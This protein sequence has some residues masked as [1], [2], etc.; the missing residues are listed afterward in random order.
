MSR[1]LG[2]VA[3]SA[4]AACSGGGALVVVE[5]SA[6]APLPRVARLHVQAATVT[7]ATPAF[8]TEAPD[9]GVSFPTDFA[10]DVPAGIDG[11]LFIQVQAED[12]AARI[13]A[14]GNGSAPIKPGA[15]STAMI[16]LT[17]M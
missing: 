8:D 1:L 13:V 12:D 5:V 14:S 4:L 3:V 2:L 17:P 15:R 6:S 9:G 7:E 11:T 16:V 10:I